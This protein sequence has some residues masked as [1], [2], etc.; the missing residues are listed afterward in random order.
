MTKERDRKKTYKS[1]F[2]H[3]DFQQM[4][5][6]K[7]L[8]IFWPNYRLSKNRAFFIP[9]PQLTDAENSTKHKAQSAPRLSQRSDAQQPHPRYHLRTRAECCCIRTP[10]G[11][12]SHLLGDATLLALSRANKDECPFCFNRRRP[13]QA[14]VKACCNRRWRPHR[15]SNGALSLAGPRV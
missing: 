7:S 1:Y 5:P 2:P 15:S 4:T 11:P 3:S 8:D 9:A 14:E 6:K 13:G 12:G 10:T